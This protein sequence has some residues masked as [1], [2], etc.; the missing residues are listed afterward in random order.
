MIFGQ[1]SK[2]DETPRD[3]RRGFLQLCSDRRFHLLTMEAFEDLT[4][5]EPDEYWIE[6]RP[7]GA[8]SWADNTRA[9]R[10]AHKEGAA[11]MGW[12]A[13]GDHCLGFPRTSNE[14]MRAKLA[15]TVR[16]RAEEFPGARHY[17]LFGEGEKIEVVAGP[18]GTGA[19]RSD[20]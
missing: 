11:H 7:G 14:E 3:P 9:A 20:S 10:L 4:G 5:L 6:A 8:P 19:L 15:R 12:M 16:K 18:A 13:H 2:L 17:A 1:E